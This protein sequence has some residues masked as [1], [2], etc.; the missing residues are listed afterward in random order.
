MFSLSSALSYFLYR[1]PVDIRNS[2]DGLGGLIQNELG[3]DPLSGEVFIFINKRRNQVK[4]LRWE[5]G[6]FILY[7]KRLETGTFE[8][9]Q[10]DDDSDSCPLQ[11][12]TLVLMIEGIS[13]KNIQ[14]RKRFIFNKSA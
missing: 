10:W 9:P 4:L 12:S 3:R 1:K 11:W 6:G 2:F 5:Q 14:K 8:L 7:Y 13:L